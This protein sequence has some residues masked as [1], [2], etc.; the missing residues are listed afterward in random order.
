MMEVFCFQLIASLII[1]KSSALS[2]I[3]DRSG[4][5]DELYSLLVSAIWDSLWDMLWPMRY[6]TSYQLFV[7]IDMFYHISYGQSYEL[8]VVYSV[9]MICHMRCNMS[10]IAI[11]GNISTGDPIQLPFFSFGLYVQST[12]IRWA[13]K[14]I[15][16]NIYYSSD[17]QQCACHWPLSSARGWSKNLPVPVL[18]VLLF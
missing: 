15:D 5:P 3:L 8:W 16:M 18:P 6:A 13:V 7:S 4:T 12:E 10:Y 1:T 14:L 2:G 9:C 11:W 17:I